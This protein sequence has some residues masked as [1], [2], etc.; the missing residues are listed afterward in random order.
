M[1][2][3]SVLIVSVGVYITVKLSVYYVSFTTDLDLDSVID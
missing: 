1:V 3:I 2:I